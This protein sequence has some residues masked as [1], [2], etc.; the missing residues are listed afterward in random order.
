MYKAAL[1]CIH[2]SLISLFNRQMSTHVAIAPVEFKVV[3]ASVAQS[4][5]RKMQIRALDWL[6]GDFK[7]LSLSPLLLPDLQDK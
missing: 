7:Y 6:S 5:G 1:L 3:T 4:A 2:F